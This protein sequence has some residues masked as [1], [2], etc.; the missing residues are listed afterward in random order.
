MNILFTTT[1]QQYFTLYK[2]LQCIISSSCMFCS[3]HAC[4]WAASAEGNASPL[5][6]CPRIALVSPSASDKNLLLNA[7]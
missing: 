4:A 2:W 5:F 1:F 3:V 7:C 6:G